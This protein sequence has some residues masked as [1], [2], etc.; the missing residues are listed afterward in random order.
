MY[1]LPEK[2]LTVFR[3]LPCLPGKRLAAPACFRLP[4]LDSL[5]SSATAWEEV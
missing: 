2:V 1:L 3:P 5:T 4:P